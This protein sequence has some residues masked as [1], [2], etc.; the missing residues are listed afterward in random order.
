MPPHRKA[1]NRWGQWCHFLQKK[2][3]KR[4]FIK[5]VEMNYTDRRII[6]SYKGL[7]EGL[8][9][10]SKIEL[11]ESLSKSL[12]ADMKNKD[13]SFYKSFG[14]FPA[15]KSAEDIIKEIKASR[16]FRRKDIKL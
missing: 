16:K 1:I 11:I 15:D 3:K 12:K 13:A 4:R 10:L 8:S 6:E 9:S 2:A 5:T 7:F 14:A